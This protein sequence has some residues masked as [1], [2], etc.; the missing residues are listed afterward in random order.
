MHYR[1]LSAL[2]LG[3]CVT[4]AALAQNRAANELFPS[5]ISL[6]DEG[7]SR[8]SKDALQLL[9]QRYKI[10]ADY[11][12]R[13]TN[14]QKDELGFTHNRYA[15]FYKNLPVAGGTIL[16]HERDGNVELING[17]AFAVK[18]KDAGAGLAETA[19]FAEALKAVPA[20]QY[21]W[22]GDTAKMP[23]AYNMLKQRPTGELLWAPSA[24]EADAALRLAYRYD[25]YAIK[26]FSRTFVYVDAETG[27]ILRKMNRITDF[28]ATGTANT[29]FSGQQTIITDSTAPNDFTLWDLT[30]GNGIHT[31]D[32]NTDT[33]PWFAVDFT[34]A[35]NAWT[36][37][38]NLDK[39][40]LDVHWGTEQVYDYYKTVHSRN[41]F[42]NA[43]AELNNFIHFD[44]DMVN[45]FWDGSA[46][47]FGD[48]DASTGFDP[49]V[50]LDVVGHE[51]THAVTS[52]SANLDYWYESGALNESFSDI[53][54]NAIEAHVKPTSA[55]WK[56][57]EDVTTNG[58]GFR[59]MADPNA[60]FNPDT[61]LGTYWDFSSNDNGGVHTNSGVQNFWFYLLSDGGSGTNDNGDSYSVTGIGIADAAKIAYRALTVYLTNTSQ[62]TDARDASI[63]A[64]TDLFGGCSTQLIQTTNAWQAVG[65]GAAYSPT[66]GPV[67]FTATPQNACS[68][69][70]QVQFTN[71]TPSA[72]SV[73]WNFG[74]GTTSTTMSPQHTYTTAGTYTVKLKVWGCN[75]VADSVT[76]TNYIVVDP[77]SAAC[78]QTPVPTNSTAIALTNCSGSIVDDGGL[79]G[80][81]SDNAYG[82]VQITTTGLY[83]E[84]QFAS[85]NTED[86]YDYVIVYD[87]PNNSSPLIDYFTGANLPY[88]GA[89]FTT[90]S[91]QFYVE[92]YSDG[93]VTESGFQLLYNCVG[94]TPNATFYS[95]DSIS[96]DKSVAFVN[97]TSPAAGTYTWD[98]GDGTSSTQL[99]PSH[100]YNTFGTYSV[101]L[102]ACNGAS[103]CNTKTKT[104]KVDEIKAI[105]PMPDTV[106]INQPFSLVN[107]STNATAYDWT[108]DGANASNA[109]NPT[110]QFTTVG[111]HTVKLIAS[112]ANCSDILNKSIWAKDATGVGQVAHLSNLAVFPN[113]AKD[114]ITIMGADIPATGLQYVLVNTIGQQIISGNLPATNRAVNNMIQLTDVA[115]GVYQLILKTE[116][117][118]ITKKI[119]VDKK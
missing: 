14:S 15:E 70:A 42:D 119:I 49:V 5:L 109:A 62:Y 67:S 66:N 1:Y 80:D 91:N 22:Q 116:G 117:G 85:F 60:D 54:G 18:T 107:G 56:M 84:L 12:F 7:V 44:V 35:N 99:S 6:K 118:S 96:C 103:F 40:A 88:N 43:D 114:Q 45:A 53:L 25:I 36:S 31:W 58:S 27:D 16:I 41:G 100:T 21:I 50:S 90:T 110:F 28:N 39:A 47:Y 8:D 10:P 29:L 9:A 26:P 52:Y 81:Y 61:Y 38:T 92:F 106:N 24:Q 89:V 82:G 97:T 33:D 57:A 93:G 95:P 65:V 32:M 30:R 17:H 4:T 19:A 69:P 51:F 11:S 102:T 75:N 64:A 115:S 72:Q 68:V 76:Y 94:N 37:N 73:L 55:N 20:T 77:N 34:D 87:G 113:P 71:T 83:F 105:C 79:Q 74:D 108:V 3:L 98:F 104:I 59:S 46:L 48:G 78:Q 86:G 2:A 112:N 101:T 13:L 111:V 23:K 63:Q